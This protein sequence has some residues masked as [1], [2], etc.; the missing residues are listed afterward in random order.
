MHPS[1]LGV[2]DRHERH[3]FELSQERWEVRQ[4]ETTMHRRHR[5]VPGTCQNRKVKEVG[6]K[7]D[8][9]ERTK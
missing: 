6:M 1:A 2:R 9:V 3:H 7:V 4:I 8:N 5:L